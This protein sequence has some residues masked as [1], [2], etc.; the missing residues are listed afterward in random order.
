MT[1]FDF[2]LKNKDRFTKEA[3]EFKRTFNR[4]LKD[5]F[6]F[7][8]GFDVIAFDEKVIQ[9]ADDIST[10]DAVREKY[11]DAAVA[12]CERLMGRAS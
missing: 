11:G 5:F 10:A 4:N 6:D 8:T 12:L 9:P 7:V 1:A 3:P 2:M